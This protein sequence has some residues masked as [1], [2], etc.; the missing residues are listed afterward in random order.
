VE[1]IKSEHQG[2]LFIAGEFRE[3]S[4]G[5]TFAVNDPGNDSEICVVADASVEDGLAAVK[6]AHDAA[7]EWAQMPPR[8]RGEILRQAFE[9]MIDRRES[10]AELITQENGK[11]LPES[12]AEVDYAAEFFRWFSEEAVRGIGE[13]STAPNGAYR[14]LTSLQP[15]GLS[16]LVTPWNFPAA[17][18]TRKIGPALAAGCTTVLKPA[19]ETPLTALAIAQVMA[20]AGMPPGVVNV[21]TTQRSSAVVGAMLQDPRVRKISFTG[22]T[23]VGRTLLQGAAPRVLRT[24]MELGGNGPFI[25]LEDADLDV[26]VASAMV[27]KFRNAGQSC[28]A[29]N[30]FLVHA[31]V[32]DEFCKRFAEA[33]SR[34]HV[35]YGLDEGVE[36]GSL[37][38]PRALADVLAFIDDATER[39]AVTVT[40]GRRVGQVGS[41]LQ[42]TLLM[43]VPVDARCMQEEIFGP[44][45]PVATFET[46]DEAV[47]VANATEFGLVSFVQSRDIGAALRVAD[48]L[49]SGM[50]GINRGVVSDPAAPFGGWKQSGL[51][52]EGHH[53]GLLEF[54]ETKY[55]AVDW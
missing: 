49:E 53:L 43:D 40:G 27:A 19:G 10:L 14:M 39:G 7:P 11:A 41:Y 32:R 38:N 3:A 45:A 44:V 36:I 55:V 4:S 47:A 37:I 52:R 2:R 9:I 31:S 22:S 50:V 46:V 18:A 42:P 33:M 24:S 8:R 54:L 13:V 20:D 26:A 28:T 48:R 16:V 35:G 30:R 29:A 17:M 6:A 23:E 25:V 5:R 51:G 21:V 15:V 34:L 12:R 1:S